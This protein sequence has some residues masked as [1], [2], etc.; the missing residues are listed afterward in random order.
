MACPECGS[1]EIA[2]KDLYEGTN[3]FVREL[4]VSKSAEKYIK[5]RD[6]RV[7]IG[8]TRVKIGASHEDGLI[9][10]RVREEDCVSYANSIRVRKYLFNKDVQLV[11]E[12]DYCQ[13]EHV[14]NYRYPSREKVGS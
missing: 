10:I 5:S 8:R 11:E 9:R 13:G 2:V 12:A 6:G 3:H 1:K 7:T 4:V 14:V